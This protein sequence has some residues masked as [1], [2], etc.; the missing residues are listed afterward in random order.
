MPADGGRPDVDLLMARVRAVAGQHIRGG[1]YRPEELQAI[2]RMEADLSARRGGGP[3]LEDALARLHAA[4]DPTAPVEITSHRPLLGRV[5]VPLKRLA[6][7]ALR[8]FA[9]MALARQAAFDGEVTRLLTMAV[10][11][12][13]NL[14]VRLRELEREH[15]ELLDRHRLLLREV[16]AGNAIPARRQAS[17]PVGNE[18][19]GEPAQPADP[20][21]ATATR[22]ASYVAFEDRHRGSPE[23]I[24]ARQRVYV[25]LFDRV[26]GPVLDAGCGRGEFLDLLGSAGVTAYGVDADREMVERCRRRG[27]DVR[28]GDL[29]DH[30]RS[31]GAGSLGGIFAAQVVEHLD[32]PALLDFLALAREKLGTGGRLL[33][34]TINPASL[35]TFSG[36]FYL[37]L[38]HVRPVHPSAL[39]RA[40]EAAGFGNVVIVG[41]SPLPGD[42]RLRM[43]SAGGGEGVEPGG[44]LDQ[45]DG[46]FARLNGLIYGDQDYALSAT[47]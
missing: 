11:R 40:V 29:I 47:A 7:S 35:S 27:L 17:V 12:A 39:R 22:G 18:P 36:A 13:G 9:R 26:P 1:E 41:R 21:P 31:L 24:A 16:E 8:P 28:P 32:T 44:I 37:D 46:N 43:T 15:R 30:L 4:W 14:D 38:T 3:D 5:I 6:T 25:A 2:D 45:L 23:E 19:G 33:L 20:P 10:R 42:A 34:E